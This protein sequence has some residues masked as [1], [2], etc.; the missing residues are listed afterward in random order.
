VQNP[1]LFL[2]KHEGSRGTL[3]RGTRKQ[4]SRSRISRLI[5]RNQGRAEALQDVR[6]RILK[7]LR[8]AELHPSGM[9]REHV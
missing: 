3:L 6:R 9:G 4:I 2:A 8:W 7:A 1:H 5:S